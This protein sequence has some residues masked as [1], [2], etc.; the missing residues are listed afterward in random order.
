[1]WQKAVFVCFRFIYLSLAA[2]CIA[3]LTGFP[4]DSSVKRDALQMSARLVQETCCLTCFRLAEAP[5]PPRPGKKNTSKRKRYGTA[6]RLPEA[7]TACNGRK[8]GM[9]HAFGKPPC[10]LPAARANRTGSEHA[11]SPHGARSAQAAN[12]KNDSPKSSSPRT[13]AHNEFVFAIC[14]IIEIC[15]IQA[16]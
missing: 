2:L 3:H 14:L 10:A 16:T 8:A 1:M 13:A 15:D 11:R 4:G 12:D 5:L 9:Q 7:R 6:A